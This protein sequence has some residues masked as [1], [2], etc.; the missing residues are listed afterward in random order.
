MGYGFARAHGVIL[1][2][3]VYGLGNRVGKGGGLY[4]LFGD[5]I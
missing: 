2:E 4:A 1:L 3:L 5:R